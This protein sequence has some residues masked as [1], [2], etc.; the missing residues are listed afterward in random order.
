MQTHKTFRTQ[1]DFLQAIRDAARDNLKVDVNAHIELRDSKGRIKQV[2]EAHNLVTTAG[3]AHIADQLSASPG[4]S[5][6]SHMEIGTGTNA[7]AAG[8]TTLQTALDRNALS[9]RTDSTNVVT[10]VASWA[11]A[12]GTGAITE[13]GIF[14]AGSSGTLL[15]RVVFSVVNK[16]AADSLTITWTLTVG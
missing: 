15:A 10:Y 13:A 14:N 11:A 12:D 1:E 5:A 8:D 7:A 2:E 3:K 16:A 6:M 9:S 4:E